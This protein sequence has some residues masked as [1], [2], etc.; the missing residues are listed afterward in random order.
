MNDNTCFENRMIVEKTLRD[1]GLTG[2]RTYLGVAQQTFMESSLVVVVR[3]EFTELKDALQHLLTLR[4]VLAGDPACADLFPQC[5][6][7]VPE[8]RISSRYWIAGG[9]V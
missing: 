6:A 7:Q 9:S 5:D 3:S 4:D 2:F 8:L 1:K